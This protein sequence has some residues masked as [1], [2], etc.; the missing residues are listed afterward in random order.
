MSRIRSWKNCGGGTWK[1][2]L[3]WTW[4]DSA[5][6]YRADS[7]PAKAERAWHLSSHKLRAYKSMMSYST[8][9]RRRRESTCDLS[10]STIQSIDWSSERGLESS[11]SLLSVNLDEVERLKADS[12]LGT[13]KVWLTGCR[14]KLDNST[15]HEHPLFLP[16]NKL[17][18]IQ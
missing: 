8:L 5:E 11:L 12:R 3:T 2:V 16:S 7:S 10:A 9:L 13:G 4:H 17:L 14:E 1:R 6:K 18:R 15:W